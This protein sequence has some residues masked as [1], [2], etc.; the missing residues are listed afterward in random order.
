ML[1]FLNDILPI[2]GGIVDLTFENTERTP[3]SED[4]RKTI[5]DLHCLTGT[6]ER[7][8][9]EMQNHNHDFFKD[10]ILYYIADAIKEQGQIGDWDYKLNPVI[11]VN[12]VNFCMD[13]TTRWDLKK[14]RKAKAYNPSEEKYISYFK[15]IDI[16][17][18]ELFSEKMN[19]VIL[20]LPRF[21]KTEGQLQSGVD[22]WMYIFNNL[23]KLTDLPETFHK[24]EVFVKLF[25]RAKLAKMSKEERKIYNNSLKDLRD[26]NVMIAQRDQKIANLNQEVAAYQQ[27]ET[28]YQQRETAYQQRETAYQR[29][30]AE[31]RRLQ[32][33]N[34]VQVN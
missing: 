23:P 32:H 16:N 21:A 14:Q 1:K 28:A 27:R 24:D 7:V 15:L 34:D 4:E 17:T 12:I 33:L 18:K 22:N 19:I 2:E 3:R 31:L 25:E 11:S 6:G 9:I 29:E 30:I 10:R 13:G 20:E 5:F 26:M 8:I